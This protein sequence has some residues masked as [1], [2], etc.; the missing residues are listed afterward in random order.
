VGTN[1]TITTAQH[2]NSTDFLYV[3]RSLVLN[4]GGKMPTLLGSQSTGNVGRGYNDNT[5]YSGD[6]CE[7]LI[8]NRA[9]PLAELQ[10]VEQYLDAKYGIT[11]PVGPSITTQPSNL[12]VVEPNSAN[13]SVV[14]AGTGPLYYRWLRGGSTI[15][16]ATNANYTLTPTLASADNN[17]QF[18]VIVSN[19]VG[20]VTSQVATLTVTVPPPTAPSITSQPQALSVFEPNSATFSVSA[21]GTVPLSYQWRTNGVNIGGATSSSYTFNSTSVAADNG[22]QISVR[23]SNAQGAV[24]S[25][26]VTLTVLGLGAV[27]PNGLELWLRGDAGIVAGGSGVS[28]WTDQSGHNRHAAQAVSG[29]QPT[30][31]V[32]GMGAS[33][34]RFDG[35]NDFLTFV[36]PVN[37]L[38]GMTIFLVSSTSLANS[39]A[40]APGKA[41]L[42]WNE[43]NS[44]GALYLS[45]FQQTVGLRFGTTQPGNDLIYTRPSS[46]GNALTVT[47]AIKDTST[48]TLFINGALTVTQPGKFSTIA[49]CRDTGNLGRGYDDNTYFGGDIAE[50]IVYSRALTG[51][52]RLSVEQY[53]DA[54]YLNSSPSA[55]QIVTQARTNAVVDL[56]YQYL[57]SASGNPAPTYFLTQAPSGMTV[58][59]FS[60][61]ISWT[62][63]LG[64]VG[65]HNVSVLASNSQGTATQNYTLG[66]VV[67]PAN[68]VAYWRLDETGGSVF[69][70][71]VGVHH[72]SCTSASCPVATNGMVGGGQYFNE[73]LNITVSA[74]PHAAL[75][76]ALSDSFSLECWVRNETIGGDTAYFGRLEAASFVEY[77][78]GQTANGRPWFYLRDRANGAIADLID[79]NPAPGSPTWR[80]CVGVVDRAAQQA[81]L[82]VDGVLVNTKNMTGVFT[83]GFTSATATMDIG[84]INLDH[85]YQ[86]GGALDELALYR[87]ALPLSEIQ[88]HRAM[89]LMGIPICT[90]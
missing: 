88:N 3:N 55:P 42:F 47:A 90:Q 39:G 84:W 66:V 15:A 74:P 81:R 40:L 87:R 18:S 27:P 69:R 65:N 73:S 21:T 71:S 70:D 60:G 78:I 33:V 11:I 62:P 67:C 22:K 56:Q 25:S 48:E 36:L 41:P 17:A 89:G 53:L 24:T 37:G 38:N 79:P 80:H 16:G 44:W 68:L 7:I 35:V 63:V 57:F 75:D 2:D 43:T 32:G 28:Q 1:F 20:S 58:D 85:G 19:A 49:A 30:V 72:A 59:M 83:T 12:S 51:V 50:V 8:Y 82:Y 61:L 52:E 76:M 64:Q 46:V 31:A 54:K 86:Y 23:V 6:I 29:S 45:P 26:V 14:A 4:Q 77:S 10:S 9:L 13:F 5:Y 34:L